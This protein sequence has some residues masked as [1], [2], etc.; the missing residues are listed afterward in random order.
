M[1]SEK[2]LT[3]NYYTKLIDKSAKNLIRSCPQLDFDSVYGIPRGGLIPA[4]VLSYKLDKPL[5]FGSLSCYTQAIIIDDILDSGNTILNLLGSFYRWHDFYLIFLMS[6]PRGIDKLKGD[7]RFKS[8]AYCDFGKEV[9]DDVWINFPY[10]QNCLK[11]DSL[12]IVK[13][14][15]VR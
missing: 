5:I 13:K 7:D 8:L 9:P 12:S 3:W 4:T 15:E 1:S 2:S 10:E 11:E 6:K 14:E